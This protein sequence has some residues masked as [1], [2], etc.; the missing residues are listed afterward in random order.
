MLR[1]FQKLNNSSN[2]DEAFRGMKKVFQEMVAKSKVRDFAGNGNQRIIER[3]RQ[4]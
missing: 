3:M 2:S 4:I 1:M